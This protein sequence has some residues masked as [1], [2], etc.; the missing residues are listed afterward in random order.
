MSDPFA[1]PADL[2]VPEDDGA[3]DHLGDLALPAIELPSTAGGAVSLDRLGTEAPRTV[4]YIYP[5]TGT[6]GAQLPDGWDSIPGAR[7]CTPETCAFRDHH[8]DL[9]AAGADV[10]GLSTQSPADQAEAAE[11]LHLPFP[12][13]SDEGAELA[14]PPLTLPVFE[15][16]GRLRYKRLTMVIRSGRIEHVFYPVFPPDA[17]AGEVLDWLRSHP[18]STG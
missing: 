4:L 2:P 11:R 3:A 5:M 12:L 1:L 14:A 17:H 15:A 10:S 6:P 18:V 7:G 13:L 16:G 9:A 8:A